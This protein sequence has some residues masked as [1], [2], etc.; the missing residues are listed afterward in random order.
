M[1]SAFPHQGHLLRELGRVSAG[2]TEANAKAYQGGVL[3]SQAAGS[4]TD[5]C[6]V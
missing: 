5:S 1:Y 6:V 2:T 3:I 4:A